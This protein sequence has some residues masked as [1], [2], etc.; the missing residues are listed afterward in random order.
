MLDRISHLLNIFVKH[1]AGLL[2]A[3]MTVVVFLQ[4]LFRYVFNAPLD[5]SEEMATFAFTWMALLGASVGLKGEEHPA[6]DIFFM[7][8]SGKIQIF[9]KTIINL[10]IIFMLVILFIYGIK[11]TLAMRSQSTAAL[12][13]S[14]SFVYVVLPI[15][16]L[17]MLLHIIVQA[18]DLFRKKE[19]ED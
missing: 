13:Y 7:R 12:G 3:A 6:L 15:S 2:T 1:L 9:V 17:I 19:K 14:V 5:W 4:V 18:L 11:L 10:S 8:L 16:A